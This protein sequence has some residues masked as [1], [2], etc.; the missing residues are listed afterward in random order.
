MPG[1]ELNIGGGSAFSREV[2]RL[3]AQRG[4]SWRKLA[5][6][7]DYTPSWLSKVKNGAPPSAELAQRCDEVLEASGRLIALA[8]AKPERP[9]HLPAVTAFFTG[10]ERQLRQL[11]EALTT[12]LW[13]GASR[14]VAI[15]GSPGAGKTT[16][17][18]RWAHDNAARFSGGQLYV[19]LRGYSYDGPPVRAGDALEEFLV[20][21]GM[22]ASEIPSAAE[23]RARLYR[24][25]LSGSRVLVVLDNAAHLDQV[26]PLLPG[27][28]E[29]AVIVTSR[30]H[31]LGLGVLTGARRVTVGPMS[32]EE[33]FA[34]LST[35]AGAEHARSEPEALRALAQQCAHL[36]LALRIAAER[37]VTG[38]DQHVSELVAQMRTG[39][40]DLLDLDERTAVRTVFSWSYRALPAESARMFRLLGLH[41]GRSV[42]T[43]AAAALT[44]TS[45][46]HAQRLIGALVSAHLVETAGR[47]TYHVHDLLQRYARELTTA[48]DAQAERTEAVRGLVTWYLRMAMAAAARIAPYRTVAHAVTLPAQASGEMPFADVHTA[49]QWCESELRNFA[50]VARLA[51]DHGLGDL[52]W[53]LPLALYDYFVVRKPW[54][55]LMSA[56]EIALRAARAT[57]RTREAG[58][59]Q[60]QLALA[61]LFLRDYPRSR[62]LYEHALDIALRTED[63]HGEAWAAYGLACVACE[64]AEYDRARTHA[65]RAFAL[66]EHLGERDGQAAALATL[67]EVQSRTGDHDT[68]LET[69]K[70]ALRL[71]EQLHND[72]GRGR[73]LVKIAEIHRSRGK[74]REALRY[75][76][77]SLD[78]RRELQDYWG[79]AD[80]H[81][82]SGDILD[83]LLQYQDACDEWHAALILYESLDDPRAADAA[84][85]IATAHCGERRT[86]APS[87]P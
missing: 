13:S 70:S 61:H 15:D 84:A 54:A 69:I 22:P 86:H 36:P 34:M 44:G 51:L 73:K 42:S 72:H 19:N 25:L 59:V 12:P 33:S 32:E 66:F 87:T 38:L 47:D 56:D 26:E 50:P 29:C 83:E 82:R 43:A 64:T 67:G 79:E 57:G 45:E 39:G 49:Y 41:P 16:L 4:L 7:V 76:G 2:A 71:C 6:L 11:D 40:L 78:V 1:T 81:L 14:I 9:A 46:A 52:A 28:G 63:E 37:V 48:V 24:S 5:D 27:T 65:E 23:S 30:S 80:V 58:W 75:L 60:A 31:L 35:V 68:A 17:A 55:V 3:L 20:A 62:D 74:P 10:R 53:K 85:R 18:L 77:L 8:Q 21:L